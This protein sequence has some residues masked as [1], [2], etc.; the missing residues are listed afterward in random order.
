MASSYAALRADPTR[1]KADFDALADIGDY[2]RRRG[3]PPDLQ[4]CAPS[5]APVVQGAD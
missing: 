2:R 4:R 3:P 5:R 1:L